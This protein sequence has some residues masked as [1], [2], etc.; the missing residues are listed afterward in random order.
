[1][2]VLDRTKKISIFSN[3]QMSE[4]EMID[5]S[6]NFIKDLK[7]LKKF[8]KLLSLNMASN[9]IIMKT[10]L[11]MPI[12]LKKLNISD[13]Q[14]NCLSIKNNGSFTSYFQSLVN[15]EELDLSFNNLEKIDERVFSTN[16][17]LRVFFLNK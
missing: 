3:L 12:S 2:V 14:I 6:Y 5:L 16:L 11:D 8:S 4:I 7:D 17:K 1:M 9:K 15:L 13:N 10:I